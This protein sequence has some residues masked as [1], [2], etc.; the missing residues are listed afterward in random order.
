M[1]FLISME[2][3]QIC[4]GRQL[5]K[6]AK[7]YSIHPYT[8]KAIAPIFLEHIFKLYGMPKNIVCDRDPTFTS[9]FWKELF[10]LH[11]VGFNFGSSYKP[12]TD[13]QTEVVDHSA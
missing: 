7:F 5:S 8:A 2:S 10:S 6:Y 9:I 12:Q 13:G 3:P 11:G 1:D 4:G